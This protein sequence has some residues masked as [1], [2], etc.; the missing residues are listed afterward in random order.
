MKLVITSIHNK[1][2]NKKTSYRFEFLLSH[3]QVYC[4]FQWSGAT[5]VMRRASSKPSSINFNANWTQL[6]EGMMNEVRSD[7]SSENYF[8]GLENLHQLLSQAN[9]LLHLSLWSD[10]L[11]A[12][13]YYENFS[14]NS[15]SSRYALSYTA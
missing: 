1:N 14:I 13:H 10:T 5:Y 4:K 12:G 6:K 11:G 9:Y 7:P 3:D 15:E 8:I 2:K